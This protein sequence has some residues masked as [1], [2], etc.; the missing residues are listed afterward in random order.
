MR[1]ALLVT[2]HNSYSY[3]ACL[4]AFATLRLVEARGYEASFVNYHNPHEESILGSSAWAVFRRQVKWRGVG[5]LSPRNMR[6]VFG[7]VKR[8]LL[9]Y[10][11]YLHKGFD[12]FH[13]S[14]PKTPEEPCDAKFLDSVK[15]DLLLL[16]SDQM[17]N[18][19]ISGGIDPVFLLDFGKAGR[20]ISLAT[21]MGNH[22]IE[23]E[24]ERSLFIRC[25][26]KFD[27][28]SVREEFAREQLAQLGI[29]S[30]ICLDPTL[31]IDGEQWRSMERR[32]KD[33]AKGERFLLLFSLTDKSPERVRACME[34]ADQIGVP[35]YRIANNRIN[36]PGVTKTLRGVTP[37]EFVW[38]I[39]HADFVC[40]DSFH[41]TA[42]AL[43]LET[44]FVVFPNWEGNNGRMLELLKLVEMEDR[45]D[46]L[47]G[48]RCELLAEFDVNHRLQA[49]REQCLSWLDAQIGSLKE[50][51]WQSDDRG[52]FNHAL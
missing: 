4:Q 20:R 25:L 28:I 35:V 49:R 21:S 45:F 7:T 13:A 6:R 24:E 37:Q 36:N 30:S 38:L 18:A 47:Q 40:T 29:D 42:F 19:S 2:Y 23:G 50:S 32:P 33:I 34:Y 39:D 51:E 31:L 5:G 16:G 43:N 52:L 22:R 15:T 27:A 12:E 46:N 41:G 3:G 8:N 11:K 1:K 10:K 44:P 26:T 9:G 14:L 17:W 48:E